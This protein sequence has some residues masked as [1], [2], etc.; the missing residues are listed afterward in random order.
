MENYKADRYQIAENV[1]ELFAESD[2]IIRGT[3]KSNEQID[4]IE[5]STGRIAHSY[6]RTNVDVTKVY[7]GDTKTKNIDMTEEYY[8]NN[9]ILWTQE[10]YNPAV[11]GNEYILF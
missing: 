6:F 9:N 5:E 7:K 2:L 11:K 8:F 4:I 10:G 1:D 3:I